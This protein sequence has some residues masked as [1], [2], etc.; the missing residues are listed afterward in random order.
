MESD[1][2]VARLELENR[3][4][5]KIIENLKQEVSENEGDPVH[6]LIKSKL[7]VS[8]IF[9]FVNAFLMPIILLFL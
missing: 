7:E 8:I 6:Q 4:L 5:I 3:S 1:A 9:F 2:K